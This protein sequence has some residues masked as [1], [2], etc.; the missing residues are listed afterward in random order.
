MNNGAHLH[1]GVC[2][3]Q[4]RHPVVHNSP[5][6][7]LLQGMGGRRVKMLRIVLKASWCAPHAARLLQDQGS[8]QAHTLNTA[9]T[10]NT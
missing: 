6:L 5:H 1:R 7:R 3:Q 2:H 9:V 4:G 10:E 8:K